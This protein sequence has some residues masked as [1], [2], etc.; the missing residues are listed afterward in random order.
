M[1]TT[2]HLDKNEYAKSGSYI[3]TVRIGEILPW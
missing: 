2:K 3:A 1:S